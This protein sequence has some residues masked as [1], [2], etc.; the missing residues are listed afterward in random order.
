MVWNFSNKKKVCLFVPVWIMVIL[1][2]ERFFSIT[3]PLRKNILSTRKQAKRT[4]TILITIICV[5]CTFKFQTAGIEKY[6]TFKEWDSESCREITLPTVV[7]ISTTFWAIVPE[8][9]TLVLNL[10]I[11]HRIKITTYRNQ[12]FYPTERTK[13]I[14]QATRVVLFLSIIFILL[15][16]PTGIIIILDFI[17]RFRF[18]SNLEDK[19]N[20]TMMFMIARKYVLMLYE[21]NMIISFPIYFF[22]IKNFKWVRN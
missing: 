3:W 17:Y 14:T 19:V 11:I 13:K 22:T 18:D 20:Q 12:K 10:F 1:A 6:S 7:N 2:L 9:L 8:F 5:W 21:T 16:S 4:L 15:I